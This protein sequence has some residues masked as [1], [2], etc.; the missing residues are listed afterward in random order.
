MS[1]RKQCE[2]SRKRSSKWFKEFAHAEHN[3]DLNVMTFLRFSWGLDDST[4]QWAKY[5]L[6]VAK[7][8]C[9]EIEATRRL[10]ELVKKH[11]ESRKENTQ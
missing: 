4:K 6:S 11:R 7:G 10:K 8:E 5:L 1:T 2:R 9:Q 3:N